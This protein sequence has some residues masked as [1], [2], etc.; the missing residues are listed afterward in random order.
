[1]D[2]GS[3]SDLLLSDANDYLFDLRRRGDLDP[4]GLVVCVDCTHADR[5]ADFIKEEFLSRRP[6]VACTRLFDPGDP[7]PADG[8][9]KFRR[10]HDP[11]LVAV[12]MVSEGVDIRRFRVVVYLTNRLTLLSFRQIVG[13]VVRIG[14]T[15]VDDHGRV[16]LPED[17]RLTSMAHTITEEAELLPPPMVI[18]M[19]RPPSAV[20]VLDDTGVER[21]DFESITS[22]GERG[23]V[24][25][26]SGRSAEPALVELAR[27]YIGRNGLTGTDP[28]SLALLASEN[29]E[30]RAALEQ[31][32]G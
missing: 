26:T 19:D 4:G 29:P 32:G 31:L 7:K 27:L 16:Y 8:I 28:E 22:V 9:R 21:G 25:D 15:N 17:D 18:V 30:L 3:I 12:N 23:G 24:S 11:W 1:M 20:K 5:V 14:P 13:R 10:S 6:I 2:T